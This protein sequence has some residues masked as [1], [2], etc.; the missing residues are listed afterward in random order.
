MDADMTLP[1]DRDTAAPLVEP[2]PPLTPEERARYARQLALPEIGE[3][4]QRRLGAARVLVVGAGGLG[5][6]VLTALAGAGVGTIGIVD[7]DVVTVSN[8]H[9]QTI[10]AGSPEGSPK[11]ESAARA[12]AA[13]NPF[14]RVVPIAERI[15]LASAERLL[16]GWD[17]I[18]DGSDTFAT[19]AIVAGAAAAHGIPLVWGSAIGLDGQV[20]VFDRGGV[21]FD[22]LYPV[23]PVDDPGG[24]CR[25]AGVLGPVCGAVG[26]VMAMETIKL[27][28]GA[29]RPLRGRILVLD[30]LDQT[31]REVAIRRG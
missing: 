6:P 21:G 5:S 28:V 10:H 26:S 30:A 18:V 14:V 8:L 17:V 2:G 13:L 25:V 24:T 16:A 22:D 1:I 19:Q 3:V 20:G 29:G 15:D 31:W 11:V 12:L 23:L 27:I 7:D 9:R 4:G